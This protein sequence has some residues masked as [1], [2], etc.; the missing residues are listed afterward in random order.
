MLRK[1]RRSTSSAQKHPG[2]VPGIGLSY[3]L[4]MKGPKVH[5]HLCEG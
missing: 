1:V 3:I 5:L 2:V 4:A